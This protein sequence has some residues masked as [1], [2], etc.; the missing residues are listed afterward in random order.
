MSFCVLDDFFRFSKKFGF[1]GIL[2]PPS[3]GIG[4]T[5]GIGQEILCLPY[6]GFFYAFPYLFSEQ[7]RSCTAEGPFLSVC[8]CVCLCYCKTTTCRCC[9]DFWLKNMFPILACDHTTFFYGIFCLFWERGGQFFFWDCQNLWLCNSILRIIRELAREGLSL[10]A[11]K[12]HFNGTSTA[13]QW[14]LKGT[15]MKLQLHFNGTKYFFCVLLMWIILLWY[16]INYIKMSK[17]RGDWQYGL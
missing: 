8:L 2:G 10:L 13:L 12:W 11:H 3:Y 4:A 14:R 6:A 1:W 5:I 15:S 7:T 9:G 16:F 17:R